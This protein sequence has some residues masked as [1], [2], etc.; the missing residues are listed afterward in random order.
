MRPYTERLLDHFGGGY[1]H[2][3]GNNQHLLEMMPT[4]RKSIGLNFG[5]PERHD[6]ELVLKSLAKAGK[7]YYG[8]FPG[9]SA[10]EQARLSRQESGWYNSFVVANANVKDQK[11]VLDEFHEAVQ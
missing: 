5:N 3:C 6:P 8:S 11:R 1:I 2:Y 9:M 7:S 4:F 10:A